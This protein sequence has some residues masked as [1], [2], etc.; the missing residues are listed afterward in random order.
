MAQVR[1]LGPRVGGRLA[2]F[3]IHLTMLG[4]CVE[5]AQGLYTAMGAIIILI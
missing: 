2:L 5:Y 3:C 1:G 4:W